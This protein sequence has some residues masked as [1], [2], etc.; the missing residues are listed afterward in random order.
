M[1]FRSPGEF[2]PYEFTGDKAPVTREGEAL[3]TPR[4]RAAYEAQ[5][6]AAEQ[7]RK[8]DLLRRQGTTYPPGHPLEGYAQ[9]QGEPTQLDMFPAEKAAAEGAARRGIEPY[10]QPAAGAAPVEPRF[11]PVVTPELLK[12]VGLTPQSGFFKQLVGK[13]F[14]KPRD[15]K[16]IE[17][18]IGRVQKNPKLAQST[19]DGV[20]SLYT[21][22]MA[23]Y[24]KQGDMFPY[25]QSPEGGAGAR[26]PFR[27]ISGG[28]GAGVQVPSGPEGGVPTGGVG[29]PP[30]TGMEGAE[31]VAIGPERGAAAQ[32]GALKKGAPKKATPAKKAVVPIVPKESQDLGEQRNAIRGRARSAYSEIGRAHV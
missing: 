15:R 26:V 24:G 11:N 22:A 17:D 25:V 27:S 28:A 2:S 16:V 3:M 21:Q 12:G 19:K 8:E 6:S 18:V 4:Q 23:M 29:V 20:R 30:A 31:P 10:A 5:L 1:L 32:P 14:S 13:D 9:Q 7:Q